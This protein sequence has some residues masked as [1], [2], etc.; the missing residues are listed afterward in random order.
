V[1]KELT[2]TADCQAQG[3]SSF[4]ATTRWAKGNL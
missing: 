4:E 1:L 3:K 2:D